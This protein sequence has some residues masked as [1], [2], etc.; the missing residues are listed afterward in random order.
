MSQLE[1]P[2]T[3]YSFRCFDVDLGAHV[4]PPFKAT[5]HAIEHQFHHPSGTVTM[6]ENT[7]NKGLL[8][9]GIKPFALNKK[10][11]SAKAGKGKAAPGTPVSAPV[12]D[13]DS[14]KVL[15][16][17]TRPPTWFRWTRLSSAMLH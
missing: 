2:V 7:W 12:A 17:L 10:P 6:A 14:A 8:A 15:G 16:F 4:V 9:L 3:V 1:P 11:A 13:A 5:L